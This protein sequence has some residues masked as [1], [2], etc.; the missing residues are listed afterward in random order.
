M[1]LHS[2]PIGQSYLLYLGSVQELHS[3]VRREVGEGGVWPIG[4]TYMG[5]RGR[6][7]K[8]IV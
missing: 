2:K 4:Y 6:G 1:A 8:E 5:R 3:L 7:I